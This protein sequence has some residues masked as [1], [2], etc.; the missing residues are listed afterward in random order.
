MRWY[1][2][3]FSEYNNLYMTWYTPYFSECK[4][5]RW[6]TKPLK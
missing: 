5:I 2:I 1:P 3:Y 4:N 6:I